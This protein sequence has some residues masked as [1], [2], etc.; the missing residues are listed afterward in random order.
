MHDT[1]QESGAVF[2]TM[3]EAATRLPKPKQGPLDLQSN[4]LPTELFRLVPS[5]GIPPLV[6]SKPGKPQLRQ[7][8]NLPPNVGLEPTTPGLRVPCSTD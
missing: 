4:A 3:S 5:L 2:T 7:K 6:L 1:L 8:K